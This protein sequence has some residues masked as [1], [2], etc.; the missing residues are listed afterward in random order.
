MID[1]KVPAEL[2]ELLSCHWGMT[3][4]LSFY[5]ISPSTFRL[6]TKSNSYCLKQHH[7]PENS[8][9]YQEEL[10]A[11]LHQSGF[12]LCP[13]VIPTLAGTQHAFHNQKSWSLYLFVSSDQPFDWTQP[14]WDSDICLSAGRALAQ[15]HFFSKLSL[16]LTAGWEESHS[17]AV[18][19]QLV[20]H[21]ASAL[22]KLPSQYQ[23]ALPFAASPLLSAA[24]A[25]CLASERFVGWLDDPLLTVHGDY[26]PGNILF[27]SGRPVCILDYDYAHK[28]S[29]ALDLGYAAVFFCS[30]WEDDAPWKHIHSAHKPATQIDLH[31][32]GSFLD[33]YCRS[34]RQLG[35]DLH[36]L[37]AIE[38]PESAYTVL[39]P[40]MKLSCYLTITWLLE[41]IV[42][43]AESSIFARA[44][45]HT[46]S[47]LESLEK[48]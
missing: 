39:K 7:L 24:Q 23:Q 13:T 11:R 33:G 42:I 47:L 27:Q 31:L 40:H 22:A 26:H 41:Q 30:L 4:V 37:T 28:D 2:R 34:A 16:D 36:L 35:L 48:S 18:H 44:L 15:L 21:L 12:A 32:F 19:D 29:P 20:C 6:E 10:L 17:P 46:A 3:A 38:K 8:L 9:Y 25:T 5:R 45:Q 1:D 43:T 14:N